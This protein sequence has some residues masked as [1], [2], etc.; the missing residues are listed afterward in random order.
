MQNEKLSLLIQLR[1][2]ILRKTVSIYSL[3]SSTIYAL[4][5]FEIDLLEIDYELGNMDLIGSLC[6]CLDARRDTPKM[7]HEEFVSILKK[8][9]DKYITIIPDENT[10]IAS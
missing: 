4:L 7:S 9:R 8:T 1:K 3:K 5:N 2:N 6:K 10:Y